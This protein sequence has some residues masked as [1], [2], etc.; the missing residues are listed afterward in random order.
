MNEA[1]VKPA[2]QS[3]AT[4]ISSERLAAMFERYGT[5]AAELARLSSADADKSLQYK[6]DYSRSEV[7]TIA[8]QE[9]VTH[10]DDFLLRRSLLGMLGQLTLPLVEELADVI[11]VALDWP[12]ERRRDEV[13]RT[14]RLLAE[15][16][17][18]K[19]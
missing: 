19:L 9:F 1:N 12:A 11:G 13:E 3:R 15:Y 8:R 5:R 17:A 2:E 16:N 14:R 18:V 7:A 4:G 10:L 6:P